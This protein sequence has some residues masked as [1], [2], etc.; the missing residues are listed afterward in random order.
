MNRMA[1]SQFSSAYSFNRAVS[2]TR[3]VNTFA[4]VRGGWR[5]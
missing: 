2:R 3:A 5:L 1:V 4:P